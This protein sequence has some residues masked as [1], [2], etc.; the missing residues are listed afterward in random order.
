MSNGV[1]AF[2]KHLPADFLEEKRRQQLGEPKLP[3]PASISPIHLTVISMEHHR[4][5]P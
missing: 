1:A 4:T 5:A 3:F 2:Y